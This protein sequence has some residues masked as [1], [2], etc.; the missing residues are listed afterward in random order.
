[1]V[2]LA[3]ERPEDVGR[4]LSLD[5][6]LTAIKALVAHVDAARPR[7]QSLYLVLRLVTASA[8]IRIKV[9]TE[10]VISVPGHLPLVPIKN[11]TIDIPP[12]C[13]QMRYSQSTSAEDALAKDPDHLLHRGLLSKQR[14][15]PS[16][17]HCLSCPIL[18]ALLMCL[19]TCS[20]NLL[21]YSP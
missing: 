3:C 13:E 9:A 5:G 21:T 4:S 7:E 11:G 6:L 1:V 10:G 15:S 14:S 19:L 16:W 8:E 18:I 20:C 17:H 12:A 2:K